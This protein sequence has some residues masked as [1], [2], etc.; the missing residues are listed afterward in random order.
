MSSVRTVAPFV[1]SVAV[2][3]ELQAKITLKN[4]ALDGK[5]GAEKLPAIT[6]DV[7]ADI[8][9]SG[10]IGLNTPILL[11]REGRKSDLTLA[12][13]ITPGRDSRHLE[14]Q[15]ISSE[16]FVDDA[17]VLAAARWCEAAL[18]GAHE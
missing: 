14:A 12:G 16:F 11:E 7:R 3:K 2:K 1:A 10:Q 17:S 18:E 9:A 13:I 5:A 8:A 6:A 4:L 15:L